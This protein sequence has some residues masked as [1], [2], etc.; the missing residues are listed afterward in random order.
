[1]QLQRKI[2]TGIWVAILAVVVV[3]AARRLIPAAPQKASLASAV[4]LRLT[5]LDGDPI[6]PLAVRGKAIVLNF[7]APWCPPCRLEIP[8]LE[9]LQKQNL[10]K[11]VVVGVVADPTQYAR[12]PAFMRVRGVTY[13]LAQDTPALAD[14][15]GKITALPTTFY[16]SPSGHVVHS[17]T[18]IVPEYI[19]RRY[20]H[21][22]IASRG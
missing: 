11:L 17:V 12:A 3:L 4:A 20:A 21:D 13:L 6:E 1:M 15:F 5:A 19:M 9:K 22:A 7:W 14:V 16:I 8:W 10:G 2:S 18:G